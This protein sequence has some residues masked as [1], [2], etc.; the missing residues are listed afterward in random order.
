M[1]CS[2]RARGVPSDGIVV[3]SCVVRRRESGTC[4]LPFSRIRFETKSLFATTQVAFAYDP[5]VDFT[6]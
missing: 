5:T 1:W 2:D 4:L 3:P 6:G